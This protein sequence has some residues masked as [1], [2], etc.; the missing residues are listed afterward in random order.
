MTRLTFLSEVRRRRN[1]FLLGFFTLPLLAH[2]GRWVFGYLPRPLFGL[3]P[4]VIGDYVGFIVGLGILF[5]LADAQ[6]NL[7]CPACGNRAL[8]GFP[9]FTTRHLQCRSCRHRFTESDVPQIH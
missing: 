4:G 9:C 5:R 1:F 7:R 6:M 2:L 3:D 8:G